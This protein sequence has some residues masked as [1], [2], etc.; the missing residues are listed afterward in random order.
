MIVP[1]LGLGAPAPDFNL[2]GV[3]GKSH[4]LGSFKDK[5][6]LVVIF[7]CNHCPYVKAYEDRMVSIQRDYAAKGVQFVAIN[8]NDD[9]AYPE[10]SFPEM[11]KRAR[12]KGFNFPY[13]RDESQKVVEAYGGVCTPHVFAFD[14]N[15]KLRYRGRI[16]D[17]K[18]ES[19]VAT[20]DLRN[21]L[22]DLVAGRAVQVPDT[23]PFGCSIKWYSMKPA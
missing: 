20:N 1:T 14:R 13:L 7:S 16:D 19:K 15:R 9:K 18:E 17:S 4:S 5:P 11:V 8:S 6:V 3:D 2:P 21:A 22:D 12:E 10:D 23:R